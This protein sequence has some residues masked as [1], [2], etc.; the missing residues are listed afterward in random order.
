MCIYLPET[1]ATLGD[2]AQAGATYAPTRKRFKPSKDEEEILR[3][4]QQG[5]EAMAKAYERAVQF[6]TSLKAVIA[7]HEK[8]KQVPKLGDAV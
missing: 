5:N 1:T 6:N 3:R 2:A 7:W 8:H 4:D